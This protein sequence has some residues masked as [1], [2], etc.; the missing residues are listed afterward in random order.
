MESAYTTVTP[1]SIVLAGY[2]SRLE[3]YKYA[4]S[5]GPAPLIHLTAATVR[6][7]VPSAKRVDFGQFLKGNWATRTER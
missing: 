7:E 3:G 1:D 4:F 6:R 5:W 2:V